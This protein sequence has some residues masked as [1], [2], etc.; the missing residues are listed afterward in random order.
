VQAEGSKADQVESRATTMTTPSPAPT[1]ISTSPDISLEELQL[2]GRNHSMPVEALR[3]D[4]TP[5]GLHYLL[6]HFDIPRVDAAQWRLGI[7]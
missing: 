4:V 3:Y 5:I 7:G 2:A 1:R 6:I